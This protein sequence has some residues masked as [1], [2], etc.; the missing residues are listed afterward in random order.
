MSEK[1]QEVLEESGEDN[2]FDTLKEF[3]ERGSS[4]EAQATQPETQ[5]SSN[6]V[7]SV[8]NWLIDNKF[9]NDEEGRN[10]LV[11]SYRELQ[12]KAD[13]ERNSYKSESEK[14]EKLKKLDGFLKENP[15][16]V[17][18]LKG[19]VTKK[20]QDAVGPPPKPDDYNIMEEGDMDTSSSKWR[21][22]Y[23]QWLINQGAQ[24]AIK[25]VDDLK[26]QMQKNRQA[27]TE[28]EKLLKMGLTEEQISD[29]YT[30][31]RNPENVTPENLVKV[32][33]S[34]NKASSGV[35]VPQEETQ[36]TQKTVAG[37]S[38]TGATPTTSSADKERENFWTGIMKHSNKLPT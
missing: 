13:K 9:K 18:A 37:A 5:E 8:E 6:E 1:K 28:K 17:K 11:K 25:Y 33:Q 21:E 4:D 20:E 12:S 34:N 26:G 29:F 7:E 35:Q 30:F 36:P 19:Y 16:A 10:A 22:E 23:D 27:Q 15:G 38:V 14:L 2:L 32:W 31:V 3:N 24:K